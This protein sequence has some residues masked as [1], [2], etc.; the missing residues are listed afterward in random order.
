MCFRKK[1]FSLLV[2]AKGGGGEQGG[3]GL[4]AG[5]ANGKHKRKHK[6]KRKTEHKS[7]H[8]D[9]HKQKWFTVA[10]PSL[11]SLEYNAR[12]PV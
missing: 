12:V 1:N 11:G 9:E 3:V 10:P 5:G 6:A 4:A 7:K 2:I 8:T